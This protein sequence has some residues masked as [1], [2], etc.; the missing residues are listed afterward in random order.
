MQI[1]LRAYNICKIAGNERLTNGTWITQ[2]SVPMSPSGLTP[3][4]DAPFM[5]YFILKVHTDTNDNKVI[6]PTYGSPNEKL[7]AI[8]EYSKTNFVKLLNCNTINM[9]VLLISVK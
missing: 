4:I 5:D 6:V 7:T 2:S 9:L 1:Q 3:P 8:C